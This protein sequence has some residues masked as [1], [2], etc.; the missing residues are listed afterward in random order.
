MFCPKCG[1]QYPDTV[2][3]CA[4]CRVGLVTE[5]Q[6]HEGAAPAIQDS[7]VKADS[8]HLGDQHHH[9]QTIV[10]GRTG[11]D[12]T[13]RKDVTAEGEICPI[14]GA[15]VEGADW[16]KCRKCE[17]KYIHRAHQDRV[18]YWCSEC[19]AK[20][21]APP[22]PPPPVP[23]PAPRPTAAPRLVPRTPA[24]RPRPPKPPTLPTPPDECF[25]VVLTDAAGK[26][27][28]LI[29][30][31]SVQCG[32]DL[33]TAKRRVDA[34][35]G[36][37]A[38]ALPKHS[39]EWLCKALVTMGASAQVRAARKRRARRREAGPARG[40]GRF[41][42]VL[43]DGGHRVVQVINVL[44]KQCGL[45]LAGAKRVV[46]GGPAAVG[47]GLERGRAEKLAAALRIAGATVQVRQV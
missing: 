39:A 6:G 2:T 27:V 20:H 42:V 32:L 4:E 5:P 21:H 44:C 23:T 18:T 19:M 43:A 9:Q 17:R 36:P 47:R 37:V 11:D 1:K 31:L 41:D 10:V 16:F 46:D 45:D 35:P 24:P 13:A 14:C 22:P 7:V 25:D 38:E 40:S 29:S 33:A 34:A 3:H 15:V 8:I 30:V 12:P 26:T 28:Q